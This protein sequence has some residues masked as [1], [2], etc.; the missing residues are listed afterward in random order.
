MDL[1]ITKPDPFYN[2]GMGT[3]ANEI[4]SYAYYSLLR[5]IDTTAD[6]E[7]VDMNMLLKPGLTN[8][9]L[10]NRIVDICEARG[11]AMTLIDVDDGYIPAHEAYYSSKPDRIPNTPRQIATKIKD[12][13]ID[14]SYA[15]TF[16]PW[17]QTRDENN[18]Q[19]VWV[20]PSVAMM[21][22]LASSERKSQLW[23]A[24]AGFNRGGLN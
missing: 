14:S 15:A 7:F 3:S 16:Y 4:N 10:T 11:D 6:P 20:P 9:G 8:E 17:V 1:D 21:G 2:K 18:G 12:R 13:D 22:V 19:L 24:P 5:A 23:F